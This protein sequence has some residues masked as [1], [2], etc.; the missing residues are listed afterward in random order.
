MTILNQIMEANSAFTKYL[1]IEFINS[2]PKLS[3]IPLRQL[4]IFTCMDTR[5]V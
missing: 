5:L 2:D 3:K 1:P 4:A